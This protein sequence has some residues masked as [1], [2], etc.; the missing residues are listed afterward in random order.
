MYV[1]FLQLADS[2]NKCITFVKV[3]YCT[4]LKIEN[5]SARSSA[6]TGLDCDG[7]MTTRLPIA[8][9]GIKADTN[10]SKG[11]SSGA[12]MP[13]TPKGSFIASVTCA[14][15]VECTRPSCLSAQAAQ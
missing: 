12:M 15:C 8:S 13:M 1:S 3:E 9:A 7:T 11:A 5:G 4:P 2:S 10:P 6:A 14:D